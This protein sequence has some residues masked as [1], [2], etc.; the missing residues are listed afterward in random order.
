MVRLAQLALL[1]ALLVPLMVTGQGNAPD[2]AKDGY[3]P[4]VITFAFPASSGEP[5]NATGGLI[6]CGSCQPNGAVYALLF[7]PDGSDPNNPIAKNNTN[8][9]TVAGTWQFTFY[10][11]PAPLLAPGAGYLLRV[12]DSIN[13]ESQDMNF[14]VD[15]AMGDKTTCIREKPQRGTRGKP[16]PSQGYVKMDTPSVGAI[17]TGT[18]PVTIRGKVKSVGPRTMHC[19]LFQVDLT[20]KKVTTLLIG[21]LTRDPKQPD[22]GWIHVTAQFK[23]VP[24]GN[25]TAR[26]TSY[27]PTDYSRCDFEVPAK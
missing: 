21:N 7:G 20:A 23:A 17:E 14:N 27:L 18:R 8:S 26:L 15:N 10:A 5:V 13:N 16:T 25:Y 3:K 6:T 11:P 22:P 1:L 9:S 19:E 4:R 2:N 12:I 24:F